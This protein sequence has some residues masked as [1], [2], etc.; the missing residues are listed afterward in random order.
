MSN[1]ILN[2]NFRSGSETPNESSYLINQQM[3][4]N[5]TK[6]Q[7]VFANRSAIVDVLAIFFGV[8]TWIGINSLWI[9]LPLLVNVLP[10]S[11][12]LASYL[13]IIIQIANVAPIL[14]TLIQKFCPI[15]DKFYIYL[16]LLVGVVAGVLM[17]LYYDVTAVVFGAERSVVFFAIV[18]GF[19]LVGCTSSVLFMPY[20]G[21]FRDIYLVTYLIGE[22]LSGLLPG[23]LGLI[24]GV[25]GNAQCVLSNSTNPDERK[26]IE[27][28]PLP[29]FSTQAFFIII[30]SLSVAALIA[31]TLLDQL[32]S[33][34]NEYASVTI[35]HGNKYQYNHD[36]Q[37]EME[38][39]EKSSDEN[40]PEKSIS[41]ENRAKKLSDVNYRGL[42]VLLGTV[43]MFVNAI[44][45]S[46]MPFGTLPYGNVTYHLSVTLSSIANP[47]ACFIAVFIT[48]TSIRNIITLSVI[49]IP[50][51]IYSLVIA[52]L[53]PSPPFVG[54]SIGEF[55]IV[56][57][58][59]LCLK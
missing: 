26:Y 53:S 48:G 34:R 38:T 51:V 27:D 20:F 39:D 40:I 3:R 58:N 30:S 21:R 54:K 29:R 22:G 33:V 37:S 24:Q 56:S 32:K 8:G 49:S 18:F 41:G 4:M 45:P 50:F 31:F 28:Y 23:I 43:C 55:L 46:V 36:H 2:F 10:E 47:L 16:L 12:Y 44:F 42:L 9:Q 14:Y 19:A 6:V 1:K 57:T 35:A 15:P 25:G 59:L 13:V 5:I 17:S 52:A 11:W 7:A